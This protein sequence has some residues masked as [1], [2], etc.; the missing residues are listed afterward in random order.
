MV[1]GYHVVNFVIYK[2]HA[3]MQAY[4]LSFDNAIMDAI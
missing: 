1:T 2:S 3:S 4:N